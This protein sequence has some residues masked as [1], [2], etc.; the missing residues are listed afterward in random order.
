M[1]SSTTRTRRPVELP[2]LVEQVLAL[3][4]LQRWL[5]L[6]ILL[7][8]FVFLVITTRNSTDP[9]T[10]ENAVITWALLVLDPILLGLG[11]LLLRR[12]WL[13]G[14]PVI[15]LAE[16][17]TVLIIVQGVRAGVLGIITMKTSAPL[18][19]LVVEDLIA[20][21]FVIFTGWVLVDLFRS[22]VLAYFY[23]RR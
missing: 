5:S 16:L 15:L 9:D 6:V 10:A 23:R 2:R 4:R 8:T 19:G 11:A 20:L 13:V 12:R 1:T 14:H 21:L 22:E 3:L 7:A 18:L 17:T